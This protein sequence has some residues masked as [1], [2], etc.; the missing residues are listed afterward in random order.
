[1]EAVER[2]WRCLQEDGDRGDN[3][4]TLTEWRCLQE[5]GDR[6]DNQPTRTE[7]RCLQEN[8]ESAGGRGDKQPTTRGGG[9][10]QPTWAGSLPPFKAARLG[11]TGDTGGAAAEGGAGG[12]GG[13]QGGGQSGGRGGGQGGG[14]GGGAGDGGPALATLALPALPAQPLALP[15]AL[16]LPLPAQPLE[17]PALLRVPLGLLRKMVRVRVE[18]A[19][20]VTLHHSP[21]TADSASRRRARHLLRAPGARDELLKHDGLRCANL[22]L[23]PSPKP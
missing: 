5:G 10:N 20:A 2:E 21:P 8:E 15:L 11:D 17:L 1:M 16:P 7:W 14:P 18:R 3:Q 19:G 9:D 22:T 4:P 12:G 23:N 6:G 13:G